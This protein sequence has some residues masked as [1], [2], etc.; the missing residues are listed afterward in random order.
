MV[1]EES[2][3]SLVVDNVRQ[4]VDQ[5]LDYTNQS[6]GYMIS[7][8]LS[9]PEEAPFATLVV[10]L[11]REKLRPA[12]DFLRI[13]S[14][15]VTSENLIGQDVTD[16][17]FD[18]EERLSTLYKTK[19]KFEEILNQASKIDDILR[20]QR[21]IISLQSQIDSLKGQQEYLKKTAENAR[22]T[23]YLSTD[24]WSLPYAPEEPGFRPKVIFKQAVRS[25]VRNIRALGKLSIWVLVY[26]LIW[27]PLLIVIK[28]IRNKRI[29]SR[30]SA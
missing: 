6:G 1:V 15:K 13:L 23:V 5:V 10:R 20:V 3:L 26:G 17:Y 18:I 21:E 8:S 24:E 7:S 22:L 16:Q 11:P 25:L 19:A 28:V 4:K 14:I 9:Q 2:N 27:L 12:L 29:K 30:R